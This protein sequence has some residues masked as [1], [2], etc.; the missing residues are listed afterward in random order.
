ME[1][2]AGVDVSANRQVMQAYARR[3]AAFLG[4]IQ[5]FATRSGCSYVLANTGS[6]FEELV[7]KQFRCWGC[8]LAAAWARSCAKHLACAELSGIF[9]DLPLSATDN[10]W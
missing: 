9:V 7:L 10:E 8:A 3:L 1:T 6:S 5:A 2:Q 4:E